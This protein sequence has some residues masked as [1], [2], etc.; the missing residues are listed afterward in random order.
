MSNISLDNV[1]GIV[2]TIFIE[3]KINKPFNG[4]DLGLFFSC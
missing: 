1:G 3:V 2:D 4:R